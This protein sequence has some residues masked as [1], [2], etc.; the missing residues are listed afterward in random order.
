MIKRFLSTANYKSSASV[1]ELKSAMHIPLLVLGITP[2]SVR[3]TK[4]LT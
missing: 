2:N 1:Y 3:L 4:H